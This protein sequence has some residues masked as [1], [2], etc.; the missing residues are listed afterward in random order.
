VSVEHDV[1]VLCRDRD[2]VTL[3][4]ALPADHVH[5]RGHFPGFPVL[6]GVV[7]LDWVMRLAQA[8]L[9]IGERVATD[10]QVKFKRVITPQ[11]PLRL[12]LRVD[13]QKARLYFTY[14]LAETVASQGSVV[15]AVS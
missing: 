2:A 5:F 11:K 15:L 3:Q 4:F 6:P 1:H 13:R 14:V 10:F 12:E 8:H 9:G 7:Q